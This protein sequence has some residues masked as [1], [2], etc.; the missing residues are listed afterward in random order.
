MNHLLE[1]I[2]IIDKTDDSIKHAKE[3]KSEAD[4]T[5]AQQLIDS[6]NND[7]LSKYKAQYQTPLDE[8]KKSI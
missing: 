3:T 8:L 6:N 2:R 7:Y 4:I 1:L 5:I